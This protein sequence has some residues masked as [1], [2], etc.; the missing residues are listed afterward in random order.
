MKEKSSDI[1]YVFLSVFLYF[2]DIVYYYFMAQKI[3][4]G[5]KPTSD[6]IHI[7]NYFWAARPLF[8]LIAKDSQNQWFFMIANMH[9][10][11]TIHDWSLMHQQTI[12]FCRL[13]IALI[14]QYGLNEE[15][16][17]IFNQASIPAHAQLSRI[18]SCVTHMGFMERM[19]A[20]KDAV[21][22]GKG[23]EFG[24]GTF[25]YPILMA[26]DIVLYDADIV[27]VWQDQKQHLEF[28]R[29]IA[30]R[31]NDHF[32]ETL[33]L[34]DPY[35]DENVAVVPWIDGRKMS[36][37][38]NNFLWLLDDEKTLRKKI[39]QITTAS[40]PVEAVKNP[41]ECNVYLLSKL[42]TTAEED[43]VLRNRYLA[44]GMGYG[45]AKEYLTEKVLAFTGEI[46]AIYH[47]LTD[48]EVKL[49]IDR[50]TAKALAIATAKIEEINQKVGFV[51]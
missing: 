17:C 35:I 19:H 22:K 51:L 6:Q 15:Q 48:E 2:Y 9:T 27:P 33:K 7:G 50:G 20:Y 1:R 42:F 12:N 30:Q 14:R 38:Y 44:G 43:V 40:L 5:I 39:K 32:G 34:P 31:F 3:L 41:D 11:T 26:G 49:I 36:K 46:Q 28:C 29:D 23:K 18:L 45:E 10:L 21:A 25:N 4:T 13:Y 47:S 37:S 24:V 8:D 16:I